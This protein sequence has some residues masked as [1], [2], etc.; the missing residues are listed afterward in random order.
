M[1]ALGDFGSRSSHNGTANQSHALRVCYA[2]TLV[3]AAVFKTILTSSVLA[4]VVIS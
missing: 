1:R 2:L 4:F 3:V